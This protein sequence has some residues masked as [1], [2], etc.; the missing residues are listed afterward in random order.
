[1]Q[2]SPLGLAITLEIKWPKST[3]VIV[4]AIS[5]ISIFQLMQ[6]YK[7]NLKYHISYQLQ[8]SPPKKSRF[9]LFPSLKKHW[10]WL[11]WPFSANLIQSN[12]LH[13][14]LRLASNVNSKL[15]G[16]HISKLCPICVVPF[17]EFHSAL[18]DKPTNGWIAVPL[19]RRHTRCN[20][21]ERSHTINWLVCLDGVVLFVVEQLSWLQTVRLIKCSVTLDPSGC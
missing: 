7:K 17:V 3:R 1:M 20:Y 6:S 14:K 21:I 5:S 16:I 8:S 4:F 12:P 15:N 10:K 18:M 9:T 13:R 19:K 2:I 11:Q